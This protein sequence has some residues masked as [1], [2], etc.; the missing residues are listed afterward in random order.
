MPTRRDL[1][2][3]A[4]A[5]ATAT[6]GLAVAPEA[7]LAGPPRPLVGVTSET[8]V[9]FRLLEFE[10]LEVFCYMHVEQTAALPPRARIRVAQ[11]LGHE[12]RH[13]QLI[14]AALR[15]HG[16]APP[17]PPSSVSEADSKLAAL[18]VARR[19]SDSHDET[20]AVHLLIGV[21]TVAENIYYEAVEL[22]TGPALRV[23][24]GIMGCE[25][26]H[27]TGLSAVLHDG[28]PVRAVPRAFVPYT[29]PPT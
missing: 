14:G 2:R 26:Q 9:L 23:A 29:L 21:E 13:A 5:G 7:A 19:L 16:V 22:L 3:G 11:F 15:A 12:R 4:L 1:L 27:W 6:V 17:T 25:A 20:E 8:G 10:Q 28:D 24:A 18:L